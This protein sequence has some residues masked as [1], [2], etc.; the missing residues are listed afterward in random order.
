M[1][2]DLNLKFYQID[3]KIN[4]LDILV[5]GSLYIEPRHA[6]IIEGMV[7]KLFAIRWEMILFMI[8]RHFYIIS[9]HQV[10]LMALYLIHIGLYHKC[11]IQIPPILQLCNVQNHV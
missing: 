6:D 1:L 2:S 4:E 10:A 11:G 9:H 3:E 5:E 7:E 8:L